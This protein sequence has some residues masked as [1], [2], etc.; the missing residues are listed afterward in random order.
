MNII[1]Y[2]RVSSVIDH[3]KSSGPNKESV[4]EVNVEWDPEHNTTSD[5]YQ[6]LPF[7]QIYK[8]VPQV[9]QEYFSLKKVSLETILNEEVQNRIKNG[10]TSYKSKGADYRQADFS[11]KDYIER[12]FEYIAEKTVEITDKYQF[13]D[14]YDV[15]PRGT[16]TTNAKKKRMRKFMDSEPTNDQNPRSSKNFQRS[17]FNRDRGPGRLEK[18][19]NI[20]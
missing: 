9:V 4:Y 1:S 3:R 11:K 12:S 8:E 20:Q 2:G 18:D 16:G 19:I 14:K 17:N 5:K 7:T 6:W 13:K 15:A 10:K